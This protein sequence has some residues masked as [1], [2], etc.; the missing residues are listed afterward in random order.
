MPAHPW[1]RVTQA[2]ALLNQAR[3]E[4]RRTLFSAAVDRESGHDVD[5]SV[6]AWVWSDSEWTPH[7][8]QVYLSFM[9]AAADQLTA[10]D[11]WPSGA[12]P[13]LL[14]CALFTTSWETSG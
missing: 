12:T 6:A 14:E 11:N 3:P 10:S 1:K 13:D 7:R 8:Y 9:H 4:G 5:G 2:T